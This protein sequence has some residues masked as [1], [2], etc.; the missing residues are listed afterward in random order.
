MFQN[1]S[2]VQGTVT[3]SGP[4]SKLNTL[5]G[6]PDRKEI[7][8]RGHIASITFPENVAEAT[9]AKQAHR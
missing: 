9:V 3:T 4:S 8:K 6:E 1:R 7:R 2:N 5:L